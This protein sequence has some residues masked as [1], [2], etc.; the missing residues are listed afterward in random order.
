MGSAPSAVYDLAGGMDQTHV[1]FSDYGNSVWDACFNNLGW[2][3]V[4]VTGMH[5]SLPTTASNLGGVAAV[6]APETD[7]G[8]TNQRLFGE[9]VFEYNGIN[10]IASVNVMPIQS[11]VLLPQG[12]PLSVA[13]MNG[14]AGNDAAFYRTTAGHIAYQIWNDGTWS[15][16][17]T[18][19][20]DTFAFDPVSVYAYAGQGAIISAYVFAAKS[21]GSIWFTY[22]VPE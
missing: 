5:S 2:S 19:A 15:G 13:N 7:N 21:D 11:S 17:R 8:P 3:Y 12:S 9:G 4:P 6:L 20:N 10:D 16:E 1:V 22:L 14:D 18:I